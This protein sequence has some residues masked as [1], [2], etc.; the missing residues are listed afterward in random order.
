MVGDHVL[1]VRAE[2]YTPT[3]SG[4][5]P[6]GA[7]APVEGTPLDLRRGAALGDLLDDPFLTPTRGLAHNLVLSGGDGP[8]ASLYCPR[9]GILL[10]METTLEGVQ[11]Y[12]ANFL[13]ERPG[14]GGCA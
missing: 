2:Q 11:V 1:T 7:L 8:A 5:I 3:D 4:N 13:G 12:T 10:E 6:T 9:T 14:K